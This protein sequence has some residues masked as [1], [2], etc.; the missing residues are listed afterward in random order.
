M[1]AIH[2]ADLAS[3][4][5]AKITILDVVAGNRFLAQYGTPFR[6]RALKSIYWAKNYL[7]ISQSRDL[8]SDLALQSL[9][10]GSQTAVTTKQHVEQRNALRTITRF[11]G[12]QLECGAWDYVNGK[13]TF[14]SHFQD[15]KKGTITIGQKQAIL[16][17]G[18]GEV[19]QF[20][21]DINFH[22]CED[23]VLEKSSIILNLRFAPKIYL[24]K[25]EEDIH[26][27]MQGLKVRGNAQQSGRKKKVRVPALSHLHATV[28]GT[29]WTY[30]FQL[31]NS[32]D[33]STI[34]ILLNQNGRMCSVHLLNARNQRPNHTFE[35]EFNRLQHQLTMTGLF[36]SKPYSLRFQLDRLARNGYLSPV[37]VCA[38]LPVV[39]KLHTA[40]GL[41]PILSALRRLS[42]EMPFAGPETEPLDLALANLEQLLS[43]YCS[44]YDDASPT[45]PYELVK[46]YAHVNL[47]HKLVVTPSG[48]RLE[49]PEAEP[50]NRVLRSYSDAIDAFIR[51]EFRDDDGATVRYEA[52]TDLSHIYNHFK[53][54]ISSNVIICGQAFSFL[55]FSHSSLRSQSCWFMR[56]FVD[57]T[58]TLVFAELLLKR[59]GDFESIKTPAKVQSFFLKQV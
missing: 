49:G 57:D 51:V 33:L 30:R 55:G 7:L 54:I 52:R 9:R 15:H 3:R 38:L 1:L 47:V 40:F 53:K 50:T 4:P 5:L 31:T 8:P 56:P 48:I 23:I 10:E 27:L 28:V 45:D 25:G 41:Q 43:T 36:R 58:K 17:L 59:L 34:R 37:K 16:L 35:D 12:G 19:E 32:N 14:M 26:E 24:I 44:Q 11:T 39:A 29:C 46:R 6:G 22:D 42:R 13:L 20:R 21:I 2:S 18:T